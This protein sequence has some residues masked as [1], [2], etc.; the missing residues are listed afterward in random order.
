MSIQ[1]IQNITAIGLIAL[2][3]IVV[4]RPL[5]QIL[6]QRLQNKTNNNG[7]N[8]LKSRLD[9]LETNHM[10]DILRRLDNLEHKQDE[11]S[12]ELENIKIELVRI[13]S[14]L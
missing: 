11:F 14:R 1:D 5:I 2:F 7:I 6:V 13:K 12:K 4:V 10:S 9:M 8:K 3:I